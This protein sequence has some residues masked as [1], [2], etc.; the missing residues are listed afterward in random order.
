MTRKI[1]VFG[2]SFDPV[3]REH[4]EMAERAVKEFALDKVIFVVAYSP[5]HKARQF[6]GIEDRMAMVKLAAESIEKAEVSSYEAEQES[7]VYSYQTLDYFQ[8]LYPDGEIF[9]LIGSDSLANLPEWK[10]IDYL[11]SKY[12]FIVAKRPGIEISADTEYL[13]RCLFISEEMNDVSSTEIRRLLKERSAEALK[14]IDE[15]VYG[16]I[17]EHGLY[18]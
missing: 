14:Y 6:A 15:K 12:K 1:A 16:Y 10:N 9:M 13:D 17:I 8:N 4:S 5:A 7:V 3:H 18:K 11:A 2:G